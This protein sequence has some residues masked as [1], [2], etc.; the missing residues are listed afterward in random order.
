MANAHVTNNGIAHD[1]DEQIKFLQDPRTKWIM[2]TPQA[3]HQACMV[4]RYV[5][6]EFTAKGVLIG[7]LVGTVVLGTRTIDFIQRTIS[8]LHPELD[9]FNCNPMTWNDTHAT[10]QDEVIEVLE[11]TRAR[12]EELVELV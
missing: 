2:H 11:K 1:I 9:I 12:A 7:S 5:V 8:E 4:V 3:P 6:R 10:S